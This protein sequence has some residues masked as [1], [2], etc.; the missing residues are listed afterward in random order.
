MKKQM[1]NMVAA[2]AL[3]GSGVALADDAESLNS[4]HPFLDQVG[5]MGGAAEAAVVLCGADM[6]MSAAKAE[7]QTQFVKIGGTAEQ[8]E[9]SYQAGYDAATAKFNA[10]SEADRSKMCE[11]FEALQAQMSTLAN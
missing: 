5:Q 9:T 1:I 8:F 4:G 3:M 7:M 2:L 6:D 11:E 10:A